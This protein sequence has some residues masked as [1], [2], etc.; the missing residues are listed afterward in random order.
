MTGI[1][2]SPTPQ[3]RTGTDKREVDM[4]DERRTDSEAFR[5]CRSKTRR[6]AER[7]SVFVRGTSG[8]EDIAKDVYSPRLRFVR[9]LYGR[10][11]LKRTAAGRGRSSETPGRDDGKYNATKVAPQK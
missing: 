5:I 6:A 11:C 3:R 7:R 9:L 10:L 4:D 2:A 1:Y 8:G